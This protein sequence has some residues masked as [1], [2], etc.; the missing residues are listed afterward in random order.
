M[1]RGKALLRLDSLFVLEGQ[2]ADFAAKKG[3]DQP[4]DTVDISLEDLPSAAETKV[5]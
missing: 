3:L 5:F 2:A 1:P 4:D